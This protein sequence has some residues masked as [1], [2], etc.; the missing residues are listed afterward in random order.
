MGG[1][2]PVPGQTIY[3][4]SKAAVMLLTEGLNSE[5]LDTNVHVT[6][7]YPGA[8]STNIAVNSGVMTQE[9][10]STQDTGRMRMTDPADAAEMI[11]SGMENNKYRVLV[12]PDARLM[13]FLM[14]LNPKRAARFI[15]DQMKG[16]LK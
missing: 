1:F 3:G 10:Q 14:R 12:G 9:Q 13:D 7:V 8:I 15:Y 5:L 4:A 2:L 11:V 16:L 6:A